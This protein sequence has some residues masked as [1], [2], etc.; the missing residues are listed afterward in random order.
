MQII[1]EFILNVKS[2]MQKIVE[3]ELESSL[4]QFWGVRV[5]FAYWS[6]AIRALCHWL[7]AQPCV[8][9]IFF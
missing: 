5:V 3:E 1:T 8:V 6:D 2:S 7:H 4:N 9:V